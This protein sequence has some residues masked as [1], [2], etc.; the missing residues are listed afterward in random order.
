MA[1]SP[2]WP[3]LPG[4]AFCRGLVRKVSMVRPG[5]WLGSYLDLSSH[6]AS[7]R[8][9][10]SFWEQWVSLH[11][12]EHFHPAPCDRFP[13]LCLSFPIKAGQKLPSCCPA[14]AQ[15][16]GILLREG[17][18]ESLTVHGGTGLV[19]QPVALQDAVGELGCLPGHIHRRSGQLAEPECAG[20]AGHC[21]GTWSSE[22]LFW[23]LRAPQRSWI[24]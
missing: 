2:H 5:A 21:G 10:V 11:L 1:V 6:P 3:L 9:G 22:T 23:S 24:K 15:K 8:D 17:F 12:R 20:C 16:W 18:G 7:P 19:H 4:P 13:R 14:G